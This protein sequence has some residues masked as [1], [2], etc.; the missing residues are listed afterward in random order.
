MGGDDTLSN[1]DPMPKNTA[2]EVIKKCIY[3]PEE[4][5]DHHHGKCTS[6]RVVLWGREREVF[7]SR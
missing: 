6:V 4:H 7:V 3:S 2:S 1:I 5:E